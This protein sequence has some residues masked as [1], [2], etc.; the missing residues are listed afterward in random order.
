MMKHGGANQS[1]LLVCF[2]FILYFQSFI[3]C[4]SRRCGHETPQIDPHWPT[5]PLL[6]LLRIGQI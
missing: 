6:A 3:V 4:K 2:S 1:S 5:T